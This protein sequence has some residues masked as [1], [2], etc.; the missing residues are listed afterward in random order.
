M[1]HCATQL[2]RSILLS[3]SRDRL[4]QPSGN[5]ESEELPRLVMAAFSVDLKFLDESV[6]KRIG[7]L[8]NR[9]HLPDA[10]ANLPHE[11]KVM[12]T[13]DV[14]EHRLVLADAQLRR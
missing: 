11:R 4:D 13:I 12:S 10:D 1:D 2:A 3:G 6:D 14:Q 7:G 5:K 8:R 9:Q